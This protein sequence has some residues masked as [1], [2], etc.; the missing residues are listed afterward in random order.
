MK[1]IKIDRLDSGFMIQLIESEHEMMGIQIP[2][3]RRNLAITADELP[4]VVMKAIQDML[5]TQL[6]TQGHDEEEVKSRV[7]NSYPM[8]ESL[9]RFFREDDE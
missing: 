8:P 2:G 9:Q 7:A 6:V 5:T 1:S 3:K 4:T